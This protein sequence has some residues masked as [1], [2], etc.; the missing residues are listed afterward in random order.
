[1]ASAPLAED[2]ASDAYPGIADAARALGMGPADRIRL[3]AVALRLRAEGVAA[4]DPRVPLWFAAALCRSAEQRRAFLAELVP[5]PPPPPLPPS[6]S[7]G[8]RTADR[9]KEASERFEHDRLRLILSTVAGLALALAV[10]LAILWRTRPVSPAIELTTLQNILEPTGQTVPLEVPVQS[11][12]I[13]P[14]WGSIAVMAGIVA[15]AIGYWLWRR[16]RLRAVKA[17]FS[18]EPDKAVPL[19]LRHEETRLFAS[20][21]IRVGLR[22]LRRHRSQPGGRL[23][24][25]ASIA[26]TI[27]AGGQPQA[28]FRGRW[29]MPEYLLLA[30]REAPRDHLAAAGE[31]LAQ[32]IRQENV[33]M[34]HYEFLGRPDPL[35]TAGGERASIPLASVLARHADARSMILA[36]GFDLREGPLTPAWVER[37]TDAGPAVHLN[38]RQSGGVAEGEALLAEDGIGSF[39]LNARGIAA[40]AQRLADPRAL[41]GLL[42][43]GPAQFDL[44]RNLDAERKL[45]LAEEAPRPAIVAGVTEDLAAWLDAEAY[46]WFAA[47]SLFPWLEPALTLYLGSHLKDKRGEPVLTDARY[48]ALA[49]LPWMRSGAMPRWLRLELAHGLDSETLASAAAAIQAF[50]LPTI[51]GGEARD[52]TIEQGRDPAKRRLLLTW[53]SHSPDSELSDP[54]LIDM[55]R[56]RPPAL[57]GL[58]ASEGMARR[59][60]RWRGSA[61]VKLC[62]AAVAALALVAL[63]RNPI[64]LEARDTGRKKTVPSPEFRIRQ[65]SVPIGTPSSTPTGSPTPSP[66][67]GAATP[68]PQP[69]ITPVP[70]PV[71]SPVPTASPTPTPKP[72]PTPTPPPVDPTGTSFTVYFD[73]DSA[74][75]TREASTVLNTVFR[76]WK[77]AG[78]RAD[79]NLSGHSNRG[80]GGASYAVG[81]SQR[82]ADSVK[83]YLVLRGV[84]AS[85]IFTQ[86]FGSSQPLGAEGASVNDRVEIEFSLPRDD[87]Q[88]MAR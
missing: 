36:E 5:P 77:A 54:I 33:A 37:V 62:V 58:R 71:P 80:K 48:L 43:A 45:L 79:I 30:E 84:P 59:V 28:R 12:V 70:S 34:G 10:T 8:A 61:T 83:A 39:A 85:R 42:A 52:I 32:R 29:L 46:R 27:R 40:M 74:I 17:N 55:F 69:S 75:I 60:E 25:R 31:A 49:R 9:D 50:L 68:S 21:A 16:R 38:P 73:R 82:L 26:A 78:G 4:D 56:G 87:T 44:P 11:G 81:L 53:L 1:M 63:V 51:E 66:S 67:S 88:Q 13:V 76:R 35:R 72:T 57:L 2:L 6:P 24:V 41:H 65:S 22:R 14:D 47:L 20:Q 3:E 64:P 86:G 15:A 7:P 18:P 23:D 19:A